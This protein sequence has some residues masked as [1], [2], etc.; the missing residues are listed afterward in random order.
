MPKVSHEHYEQ[1]RAL[2]DAGHGLLGLME[3]GDAL[4]RQLDQRHRD[5]EASDAPNKSELH[6]AV[7][8]DPGQSLILGF[9]EEFLRDIRRSVSGGRG[10]RA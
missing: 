7:P 9:A 5:I 8:R 2:Y 6:D 4:E 3:T 10:Q 1:G